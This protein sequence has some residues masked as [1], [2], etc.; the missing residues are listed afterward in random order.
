MVD[1]TTLPSAD[2]GGGAAWLREQLGG[3]AQ[4]P[5]AGRGLRWS[6]AVD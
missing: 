2:D 1:T 4:T 5:A 3:S 6:A